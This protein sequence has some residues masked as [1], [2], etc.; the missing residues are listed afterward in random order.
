MVGSEIIFAI[1]KNYLL[2]KTLHFF[3][4]NVLEVVEPNEI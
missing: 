2:S 4:F 1:D 3:Y